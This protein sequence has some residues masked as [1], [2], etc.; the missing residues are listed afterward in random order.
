MESWGYSK[1]LCQP[2]SYAWALENP[3]GEGEPRMEA[4]MSP[5]KDQCDEYPGGLLETWE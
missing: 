5:T 4:E 3:Q 1:A 2:D